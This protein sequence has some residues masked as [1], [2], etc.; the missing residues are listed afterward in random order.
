MYSVSSI[1]FAGAKE[2]QQ[3]LYHCLKPFQSQER[4]L[5][6]R[7]VSGSDQGHKNQQVTEARVSIE[8]RRLPLLGSSGRRERRATFCPAADFLEPTHWSTDTLPHQS[9]MG[10]APETVT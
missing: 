1:D 3:R 4:T 9:S 7:Q 10:L 6:R 2:R 8:A 5:P